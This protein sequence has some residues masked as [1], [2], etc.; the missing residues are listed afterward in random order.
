MPPDADVLYLKAELALHQKNTKDYRKALEQAVQ[1][2]PTHL[3]AAKSFADLLAVEKNY[4]Q[5]IR[6]LVQTRAAHPRDAN[7]LHKLGNVYYLNG[8]LP[9]AVE[10]LEN[11]LRYEKNSAALY[12]DLARVYEKMGKTSHSSAMLQKAVEIDPAFRNRLLFPEAK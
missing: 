11:A 1:A 9:R 6:V 4:S 2:D 10:N 3:M 7:L 12:F 5:S 8:D